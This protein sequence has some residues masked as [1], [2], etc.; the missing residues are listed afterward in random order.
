MFDNAALYARVSTEGQDIT[1]QVEDLEE[2]ADDN[3]EQSH[4]FKDDGV[5]ARKGSSRPGFESMEARLKEFDAVVITR[6]DRLGRTLSQLVAFV[7]ELR[8]NDIDLV[9]VNE[10]IDTSSM[11]GELMLNMLMVF[12]DYE[13][14]LIRERMQAGYDEA[15]AE[16][17]IGPNKKQVDMDELRKDY[18][19]GASWE[20]MR[21][22][23]QISQ[24]T[25]Q[26][27]LK[28]LGVI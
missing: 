26:K 25:L 23:H 22:K 14:K 18:E 28:E 17:R 24:G 4:L 10:T 6:L 3:A 7:E 13:R 16:G 12:A 15:L 20:F 27:R 5:S 21:N 19:M 11:Q 1:P 9:T 2:W 8:D